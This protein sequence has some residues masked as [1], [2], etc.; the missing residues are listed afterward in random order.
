MALHRLARLMEIQLRAIDSLF[1]EEKGEIRWH[2]PM[3]IYKEPIALGG[4]AEP[5]WLEDLGR[6]HSSDFWCFVFSKRSTQC[7]KDFSPCSDF[8]LRR[9]QVE[10]GVNI[11]LIEHQGYLYR[12]E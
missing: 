10:G 1:S 6:V 9:M 5:A 4:K 11:C 12:P 2:C 7:A 3:P 8:A